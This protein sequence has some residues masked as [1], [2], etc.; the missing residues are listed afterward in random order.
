[1]DLHILAL[2]AST[3]LIAI[4][5]IAIFWQVTVMDSTL[6]IIAVAGWKLSCKLF[7]FLYYLISSF[8]IWILTYTQWFFRNI[9]ITVP[10]TLIHTLYGIF[11]TRYGNYSLLVWCD[12]WRD[13]SVPVVPDSGQ[14][15]DT[16]IRNLGLF[17]HLKNVSYELSTPLLNHHELHLLS[18]ETKGAYDWLTGE[19]AR[20]LPTYQPN[21]Q[22][23]SSI[24]NLQ[25]M[26]NSTASFETDYLTTRLSHID[27]LHS[28]LDR[29][30]ASLDKR[31]EE[32]TWERLIVVRVLTDNRTL[33]STDVAFQARSAHAY[34]HTLHEV[35]SS[36]S[37]LIRMLDEVKYH[38]QRIVSASASI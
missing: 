14:A 7:R 24:K 10:I 19:I 35:F 31:N 9:K 38:C 2:A 33:W 16:A 13:S 25:L 5:I 17:A 11:Y 30:K 23:P 37:A 22:I 32:S 21:Y 12:L 27:D 28:D 36:S 6:Q 20:K 8:P 34:N 15:R 18:T 29:H 1:M 26:L 3:T 4:V